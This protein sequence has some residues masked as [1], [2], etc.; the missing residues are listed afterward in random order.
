MP[1]MALAAAV[2]EQAPLQPATVELAVVVIDARSGKALDE[3]G[4]A[5]R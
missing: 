3:L 1:L 5:H 2:D 4:V